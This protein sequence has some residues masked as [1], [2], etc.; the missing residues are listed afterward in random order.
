MNDWMPISNEMMTQT[1]YNNSASREVI[2]S[3]NCLLVITG[4]SAP[5]AIQLNN[6]VFHN[7]EGRK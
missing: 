5:G 3:Q 1:C 4:K 6:R 2:V 7:Q